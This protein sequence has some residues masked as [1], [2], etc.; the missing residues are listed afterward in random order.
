MAE[1]DSSEIANASNDEK[2]T[3]DEK[4]THEEKSPDLDELADMGARR[5]SVALNIVENPLK[6]SSEN[7]Q[8]S[9]KLP[10][11]LESSPWLYRALTL[12]FVFF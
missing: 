12:T 2:P 1:K 3:Y 7:F 4:T 10:Q 9:L 8:S 5:Q 11:A 6:V